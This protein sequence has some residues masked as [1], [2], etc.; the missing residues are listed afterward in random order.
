MNAIHDPVATQSVE[1]TISNDMVRLYK[2]L[3]GRGPT[4]ARTHFAGRDTIVCTLEK[5]LT[6]AE[7]TLVDMGEHE[8]LRE[9]R[10]FYQYSNSRHFLEIVERAT[11]R[12]VRAFISG[13]DPAADVSAEVFVLEP[14]DEDGETS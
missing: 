4:H 9:S 2:D 5:S 10:M 8:R 7:R 11:G 12:A 1:A 3:F 6:P 13:I 14:P